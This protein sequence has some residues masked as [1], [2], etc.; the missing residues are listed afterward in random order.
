M[1]DADSVVG[2]RVENGMDERI[3][4]RWNR[5]SRHQLI[6]AVVTSIQFHHASPLPLIT[7]LLWP[8]P[9]IPNI[10]TTIAYPQNSGHHTRKLIAA[11]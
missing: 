11:N 1:E 8:A 9:P 10:S 3:Y 4:S 5:Q 6:H 7:I 2:V